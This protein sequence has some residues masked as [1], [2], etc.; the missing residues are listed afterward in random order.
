MT[1][2][3]STLSE[4]MMRDLAVLQ[5][6][7]SVMEEA[8]RFQRQV[9]QL[10]EVERIRKLVSEAQGIEHIRKLAELSEVS[11]IAR[12]IR[13]ARQQALD[14]IER[15]RQ[16]MEIVDRIRRQM[17]AVVSHDR[18]TARHKAGSNGSGRKSSA[19]KSAKSSGGDGGGGGGDGDGDGP[20]RPPAR[21]KR[22]HEKNSTTVTKPQTATP[23]TIS[24]PQ[25]PVTQ[26]PPSPQTSLGLAY[27]VI[28]GALLIVFFAEN[29]VFAIV[30]F[31]TLALCLT[32][33]SKVVTTLLTS[34]AILSWL[35]RICGKDSEQ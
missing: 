1:L 30:V 12:T 32:G 9:A 14:Q 26:S 8:Q 29:Q 34:K 25:L 19:K 15:F 28:L 31:A 13:A 20:Q 18:P 10:E 35:A 7:R 3:I 4:S 33:H 27:L 23:S 2:S 21:P 11:N 5:Q 17:M 22:P 16:T 6:Q 24:P